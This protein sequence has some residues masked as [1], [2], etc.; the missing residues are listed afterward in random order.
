L[1]LFQNQN[2]NL[3]TARRI[4]KYKYVYFIFYK[5]KKLLNN[6]YIMRIDSNKTT[7]MA[8]PL[9]VIVIIVTALIDLCYTF[10]YLPW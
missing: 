1:F 10:L 3:V 6:T 2:Q 9:L 7:Q 8:S 5:N 4:R